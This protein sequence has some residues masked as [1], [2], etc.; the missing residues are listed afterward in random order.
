MKNESTAIKRQTIDRKDFIKQVG[1]SIG[2]IILLNCLQSCT[3]TEIPDPVGPT[4]STKLDI[5]LDLTKSEYSKLANA[6][7]FIV[8]TSQKVIVAR[9][10]TGFLAVQSTCTHA[11]NPLEYNG[12]LFTC[13]LHGSK[14]KETG[15]V[16]NGPATTALKKYNTSYLANN[17]TLRIF[18]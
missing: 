2:G 5:T 8:L 1:M 3:E 16:S 9:T 12:S 6:G 11:N 4:T 17:N 18:E 13:D 14:F 15:E 10:A 7:G